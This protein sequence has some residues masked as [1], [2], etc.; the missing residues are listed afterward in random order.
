MSNAQEDNNMKIKERLLECKVKLGIK[1]DYGL[2]KALKSDRRRISEYMAGTRKPDA[3]IAVKM[4]EILKVHPLLLLAEFE[5]ET[6]KNEEKRNF[7]INFAQRIKSGAAGMWASIFTAI[8]FIEP[9][10]R[11]TLDGIRIM[12]IM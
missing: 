7:W 10:V 12:Y 2:A 1:S 6:E 11:A 8:W 9:S 3:Y 5:S 4:A